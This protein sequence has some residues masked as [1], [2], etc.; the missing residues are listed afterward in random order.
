MES[1][2][3][4]GLYVILYFISLKTERRDGGEIWGRGKERGVREE[5]HERT[6][7]R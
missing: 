3:I 1:N 6:L 7:A 4:P 2:V 5:M